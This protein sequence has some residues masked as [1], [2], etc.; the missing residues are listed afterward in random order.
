MQ[1]FELIE[2]IKSLYHESSHKLNIRW[3]DLLRGTYHSLV[4]LLGN[5]KGIIQN[6]DKISF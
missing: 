4:D 2:I 1:I 6:I 3:L 5:V